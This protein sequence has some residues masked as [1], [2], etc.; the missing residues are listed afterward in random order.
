MKTKKFYTIEKM[1]FRRGYKFYVEEHEINRNKYASYD[2]MIK[3]QM[4]AG[5][6]SDVK[7]NFHKGLGL[8][9]FKFKTKLKPRQ[10][11]KLVNDIFF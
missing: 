9:A 7:M 5:V 6:F 4:R 2:K 8:Y 11:E 3:D 10:F 1:W